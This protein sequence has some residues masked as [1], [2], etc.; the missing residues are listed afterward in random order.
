MKFLPIIL[1]ASSVWGCRHGGNSGIETIE[2]Q[3]LRPQEVLL[4]KFASGMETIRLETGD[5]CLI[6]MIGGIKA[7]SSRIY[8]ADREGT[9]R[10]VYGEQ[11]ATA[12]KLRAENGPK[13]QKTERCG[14]K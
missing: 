5:D 3:D 9:V 11:G 6:G 13:G 2:I 14:Q 1:L 4:S 12:E 10:L 7:D 8:I